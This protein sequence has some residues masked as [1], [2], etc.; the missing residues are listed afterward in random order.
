MMI[1]AMV[2]SA[3]DLVGADGEAADRHHRAVAVDGAGGDLRA[4]ANAE[5]AHAFE[6]C[7]QRGTVEGL[8]PPIDLCVAGGAQHG[9]RRLGDALQQQ[10]LDLLFGQRIGKGLLERVLD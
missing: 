10:D 8:G 9:H 1:S 2:S 7:A 5:H 3:T 6:R 4:R